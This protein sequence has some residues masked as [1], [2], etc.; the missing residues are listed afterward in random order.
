MSTDSSPC[1][2][3]RRDWY[4]VSVD[5]IISRMHSPASVGCK[6]PKGL[7]ARSLCRLIEL[8]VAMPRSI[9][10]SSHRSPTSRLDKTKPVVFFIRQSTRSCRRS[11]IERPTGRCHLSVIS[12]QF[13]KKTKTAFC[14]NFTKSRCC[15]PLCR[16]S[17]I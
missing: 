17:L 10:G 13:Q 15:G 4:S 2:T 8:S 1:S 14:F 9:Y 16:N 3:Q 5:L 11:H 7:F 6:C 12:G